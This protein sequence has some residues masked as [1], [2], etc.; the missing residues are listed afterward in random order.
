MFK[1]KF[2]SNSFSLNGR[3]RTSIY[4]QLAGKILDFIDE[5]FYLSEFHVKFYIM[6]YLVKLLV[7]VR[8]IEVLCNKVNISM[9]CFKSPNVV[10]STLSWSERSD[11]YNWC[12]WTGGYWPSSK[13]RS[14]CNEYSLLH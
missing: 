1:I 12:A 11:K 10:T 14:V 6:I 3:P 9:V 5:L 7:T 13:I 4:L 2:I 8:I